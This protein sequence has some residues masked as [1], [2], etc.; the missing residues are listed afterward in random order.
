MLTAERHALLLDRLHADGRIVTKTIAAELGTSED[1]V[2]RGAPR[3]SPSCGSC[4]ATSM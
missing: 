3:T 2:R 1:T 4:P